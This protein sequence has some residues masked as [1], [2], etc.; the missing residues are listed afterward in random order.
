MA[1]ILLLTGP[2]GVGKT[3]VL[4]KVAASLAA[5]RLAGFYTEEIRAAGQRTGF[6]LVTFDGREAVMA[7]T[8]FS[9]RHRIGKYGVD[10]TVLDHLAVAALGAAADLYLVDEIGKMECLSARFVQA[11]RALLDTSR[12]VVATVARR[13]AGFIAEVKVR[14]DSELWEVTRANRDGLSDRILARLAESLPPQPP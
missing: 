11:M 2:P 13:G 14:R 6:R 3:T 1:V 9:G 7:S 4:R 10:L 5:R 8:R 12:P